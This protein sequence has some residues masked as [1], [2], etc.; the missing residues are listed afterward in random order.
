MTGEAASDYIRSV[1]TPL[2]PLGDPLPSRGPVLDGIKVVL[3][4]VYGTL[5]ISDVHDVPGEFGTAQSGPAPRRVEAMGVVID[6]LKDNHPGSAA[7]AEP[8][9]WADDYDQLIGIHQERRRIAGATY[10]EVDILEVWQEFLLSHLSDSRHIFS[11]EAP[12]GILLRHI[13]LLHECAIHPIWVM[14]GA[15]EILRELQQAGFTLGIV[16]NAQWYTA[17]MLAALMGAPPEQL[18]FDP[19]LTVYSFE[20]G[21]GKPAL[22]L[23]EYLIKK[24]AAR[25]VAPHEAIMI[26]NDFVKDVL[27]ARQLGLRTAWFCRDDRTIR[28]KPHDFLT[29]Q[30]LPDL[31]IS[32]WEHL[33]RH[34]SFTP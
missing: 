7:T 25:G 11:R 2:A 22:E 21:S 28:F 6:W 17:E 9:R 30:K 18:G 26:G 12:D 13:S 34:L 14:P 20:Q 24:L 15:R 27:P 33:S 31:L 1:M 29:A 19:E 4:D 8:E 3:F 16:S 5:L 10:P 32:E 23:Y